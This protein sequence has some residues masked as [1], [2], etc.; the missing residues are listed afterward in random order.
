MTSGSAALAVEAASRWRILVLTSLAMLAFAA[1]SL[2]CRLALRDASIDAATFTSIRL[3]AGALA[4][5]LILRFRGQRLQGAGSWWSG[6]ALFAYAAA[7]SFAYLMLTAATGALLL[8]GSVQATMIGYALLKR[9]RFALVQLIGFVIACAGLIYLLAPG[10]A[11]PPLSGAALMIVAG[12]A[13]GMYSLRGKGSGDPTLAT[14]G[15][16]ARAV[17]FTLALSAI[18][19]P[20]ASIDA[21]GVLYAVA[22]GALTSGVGYVIWYAAVRMIKST[23]AAIVQLSVPVITAVGGV[24]LLGEAVSLR[25]AFASIAVLGGIALVLGRR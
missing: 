7:F 14:A 15:N 24:V 13:W 3:L 5:W 2:L 21:E 6:L 18:L 11:A 25:L 17:V 12:V 8:F 9:E 10:V 16:F 23:S 19:L 20:Q 1:N 4:L 22:S